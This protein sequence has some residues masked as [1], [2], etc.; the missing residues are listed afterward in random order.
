MK[1]KLYWG[2]P[3]NG[4]SHFTNS[5][6]RIFYLIAEQQINCSL[7]S[8]FGK[9]QSK[10]IE[11]FFDTFYFGFRSLDFNDRMIASHIA[12]F[13]DQQVWLCVVSPKFF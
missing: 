8:D 3:S 12:R 9:K 11:V 5:L 6:G 2:Q 10:C 13:M 4:F 7:I 1:P